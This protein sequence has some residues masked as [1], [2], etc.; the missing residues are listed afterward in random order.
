[1]IKISPSLLAADFTNLAKDIELL[2]KAGADMLHIDIMDGIF[3]PN[4]TFG[5]DQI[6]QLKQITSLCFDVH[7]MID[8]PERYISQFAEAGCDIITVHA[9]AAHHLNK[10]IHSIKSHGVKVGVSLNPATSLSVLDYVLDDIDM[11]LIMCVNPG[12]GGQQ[13]IPSSIKKIKDTRKMIGDRNI[14]I[15]VDGGINLE[16]GPLATMAGAN[17][18]VAGSYTF[19]GNAIENIKNLRATISEK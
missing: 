16:T 1:M 12:Y 14:E 8:D 17:I 15:E 7:L 18:L 3:V 11:V 5:P 9:E 6:R 2:E 4:I 19:N 10:T 13:F